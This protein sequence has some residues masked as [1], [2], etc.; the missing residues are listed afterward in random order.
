MLIAPLAV[1]GLPGSFNRYVEMYRQQGQL[2]SFLLRITGISFVATVFL[3]IALYWFAEPVSMWL[4]RDVAQTRLVMVM[5][6]LSWNRLKDSPLRVA[7][8]RGLGPITLGILFSVGLTVMR[9]ADHVWE[10]YVVSVL[11]CALMLFT[12]LS[13]LYFML[14]AGV[15]GG[16]GIIHR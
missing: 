11:V 12:R 13:P 10:A 9:T 5:A 6:A 1:L 14:V 4:F 16:L 7:F 3:S 2:R 8:E 15:L